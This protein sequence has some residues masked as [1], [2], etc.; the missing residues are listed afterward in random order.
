MIYYTCEKS[1]FLPEIPEQDQ[2]PL[3]K[4]LLG[5]IE[6]MATRIQQQNEEIALLKDEI[7]IL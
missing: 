5:N 6:Q 1:T 4:T 7:N 2:T 3:V